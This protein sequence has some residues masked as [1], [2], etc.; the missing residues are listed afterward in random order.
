VAAHVPPASG[1]GDRDLARVEAWLR[2]A[3]AHDAALV[4]LR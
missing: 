1:R 4:E 2:R 3:T